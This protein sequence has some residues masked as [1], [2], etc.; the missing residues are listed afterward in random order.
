MI[1]SSYYGNVKNLFKMGFK[2]ADL[3]GISVYPCKYLEDIYYE[4]KLFVNKGDLWL[5][6]NNIITWSEYAKKY[7]DKL[8]NLEWLFWENFEKNFDEKVFLC[9]EKEN[10]FCH[11]KLVK[12]FYEFWT[13]KNNFEEI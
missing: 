3:V 6:K 5:L 9:F 7:Y 4:K 1:Y 12:K 11:R 13:G 8:Y 2:K 10:K